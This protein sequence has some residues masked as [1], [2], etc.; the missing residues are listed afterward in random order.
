[1][2]DL[3]YAVLHAWAEVSDQNGL[4]GLPHDALKSAISAPSLFLGSVKVKQINANTRIR[5]DLFLIHLR[6]EERMTNSETFEVE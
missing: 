6:R 1:M 4:E 3:I 5:V 2:D